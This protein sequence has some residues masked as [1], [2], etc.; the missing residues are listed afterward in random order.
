[1]YISLGLIPSGVGLFGYISTCSPYHPF[2]IIITLSSPPSHSL[3]IIFLLLKM[4]TRLISALV[5]LSEWFLI[6]CFLSGKFRQCSTFSEISTSA[7]AH[8]LST[9][10]CCFDVSRNNNLCL[11][12]VQTNRDAY[13]KWNQSVSRSISKV[14]SKIRCMHFLVRYNGKQ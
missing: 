3:H 10:P 2:Q 14:I 6:Q 12:V 4:H 9:P 1:M 11:H 13:S 5:P 7:L 8:P